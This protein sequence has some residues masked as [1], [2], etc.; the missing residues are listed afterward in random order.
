MGFVSGIVLFARFITISGG[1]SSE[2]EWSALETDGQLSS[3]MLNTERVLSSSRKQDKSQNTVKKFTTRTIKNFKTGR[4]FR[5]YLSFL[6]KIRS[7]LL[8]KSLTKSL[9]INCKSWT[10]VEAFCTDSTSLPI[11]S[12]ARSN[13]SSNSSAS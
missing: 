7:S 12:L 5:F 13:R 2:T 4:N 3:I 1:A 10:F 9:P 8:S 11:L 6:P